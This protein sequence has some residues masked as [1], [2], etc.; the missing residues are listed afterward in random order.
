MLVAVVVLVLLLLVALPLMGAFCADT[1]ADC[2]KPGVGCGGTA[3]GPFCVAFAGVDAMTGVVFGTTGAFAMRFFV[4]DCPKIPSLKLRKEQRKI[5]EEKKNKKKERGR[6][7][8]KEI[9]DQI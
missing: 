2:G 4:V 9:L 3:V 5:V 8:R 1:D 7:K 6:K